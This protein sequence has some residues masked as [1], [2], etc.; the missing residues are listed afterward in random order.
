MALFGD[1][2]LAGMSSGRKPP[3]N[4]LPSDSNCLSTYSQTG[5][6]GGEQQYQCAAVYYDRQMVL[7]A[8]QKSLP[9]GLSATSSLGI[10]VQHRPPIIQ[11]C[12]VSDLDTLSSFT[13]GVFA[14][15]AVMLVFI[16]VK[17]IF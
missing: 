16:L 9:T 5:C 3:S 15:C 6:R 10:A 4:C 17:K 7:A 2:G 14:G 11:A 1:K 13:I 8:K 12:P